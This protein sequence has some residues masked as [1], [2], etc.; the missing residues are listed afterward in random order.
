MIPLDAADLIK[1]FISCSDI[2]LNTPAITAKL[3]ITTTKLKTNT[4][5][6]N[7]HDRTRQKNGR[8]ENR[9]RLGI[10]DVWQAQKG[11]KTRLMKRN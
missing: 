3:N 10:D 1:A 9:H 2:S 6:A 7:E 4:T 5:I 8:T 11:D